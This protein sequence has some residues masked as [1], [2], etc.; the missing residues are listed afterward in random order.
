MLVADLVERPGQVRVEHPRSFRVFALN[1]LEH[2]SDR[3]LAATAGPKSVG[4]RFEPCLPL[5]LQRVHDPGL[6]NPVEDHGNTERALFAA[7]LRDEHTPDRQGLERIR[8]MMHPVNQ[9]QLGLWGEHHL[10][11]HT[12]RQTSSVALGHPAHTHQR[13]RPGPEHQP[14]QPADPRRSPALDAVKIR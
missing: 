11:V 7:C 3:V 5:G 2:R 8:V 4:P 10:P 1:D 12:R 14:L 9:F 6:M 13:V